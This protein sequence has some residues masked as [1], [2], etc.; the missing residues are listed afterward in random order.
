MGYNPQYI[1]EYDPSE[2]KEPM[3]V[4]ILLSK[5]IN[6]RRDPSD[7]SG[8]YSLHVFHNLLQIYNTALLD[9]VYYPENAIIWSPYVDHPHFLVRLE[10]KPNTNNKY[11]LVVSQNDKAFKM[12]Y[13]LQIYSNIKMKLTQIP[14]HLQYKSS[15][16]G[17]WSKDN[18]GGK[19]L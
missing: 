2:L 18:S 1:L 15:V 5:H 11:T 13:T 8:L 3:T 10:I 7:N 4:L 6:K 19:Y 17:E 12:D 9:R 14:L 16:K